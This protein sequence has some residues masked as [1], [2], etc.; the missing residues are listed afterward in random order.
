MRRIS[1][2]CLV[3]ALGALL[4]VSAQSEAKDIIFKWTDK[5]PKLQFT[6][7][8]DLSYKHENAYTTKYKGKRDARGKA[9]CKPGL[10]GK[11]EVF[12]SFRATENRGTAAKYLVDGKHVRTENQ[13]SVDGHGKHTQK[14]PEIS[15]G[16]FELKPDSVVM[17]NADDGQSY[18]C[19]GFRFKPSSGKPSESSGNDSSFGD[20]INSESGSA[21]KAE[22]YT[23]TSDGELV[24]EPY[25]TTYNQALFKVSVDGKDILVWQRS[26][27][28]AEDFCIFD[29]IA[30]KKSMFLQKAGDYS[31]TQGLS[32]KYKVKQGQ[33]VA[34][35]KSGDY[36]GESYLK[37]SGPI[38]KAK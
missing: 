3:L 7:S 18:S 6:G 30:D 13:R 29:G 19:T 14:F 20:L 34:V 32:Y 22:A 28:V 25:L 8:W 4:F 26:G 1:I 33:Q 17:M 31:P 21:A 38:S 11:Y 36:L 2:Y 9:I 16:V 24:I 5:T 15:L 35:E 37:L 12:A 10:E 23:V 27:D